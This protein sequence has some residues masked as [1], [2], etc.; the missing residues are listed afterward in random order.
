MIGKQ[1]AIFFSQS[2]KLL[3]LYMYVFINKL[4][5]ASIRV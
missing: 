4:K 5:A 1:I 3:R 2:R